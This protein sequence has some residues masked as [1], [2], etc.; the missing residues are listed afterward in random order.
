[1]S[2]LLLMKFGYPTNMQHRNLAQQ[3][4]SPEKVH[5]V[6]IESLSVSPY[7]THLTVRLHNL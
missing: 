2:W 7:P 5:G 4:L 1:M 6:M 3:G